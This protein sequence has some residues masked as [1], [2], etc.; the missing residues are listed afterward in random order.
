MMK[1]GVRR[2]FVVTRFYIGTQEQFNC[3]AIKFNGNTKNV[4]SNWYLIHGWKDISTVFMQKNYDNISISKKV[5]ANQI[6]K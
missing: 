4:T 3:W 5:L 1:F 2:S 6:Q